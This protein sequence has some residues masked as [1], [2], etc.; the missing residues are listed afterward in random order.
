MAGRCFGSTGKLLTDGGGLYV[1]IAY[2]LRKC[3]YC[4]FFSAGVRIADWSRYVDA[5]CNELAHRSHE[6]AW[7]LRTVYFGGGTP[8]LMPEEEFIRLSTFLKPYMA[9]VEE[10]TIE[11]NPDD[12]DDHMLGVWK[13]GGINRLSIGIQTFDDDA[14]R[15]IGRRH[16]SKIAKEAYKRARN[17]FGNISIDLMFG[18]PGQSIEAWRKDIQ[19]AIDM[20]PEHISAYSLMYEEGTALT[21]L[22]DSGRLME[23]PEELSE[24]MFTILVEELSRA[25]YDHYEISNFAL[26]GYRSRHNSSYWLQKP[27]IGLGPS[28]HSYDGLRE[29]KS[30]RATL[31]DYMGHWTMEYTDAYEQ[32]DNITETETLSDEEL[33]EEYILTRMRMREGIPLQDYRNRFGDMACIGLVKSCAELA[34]RGLVLI[35]DTHI[36]LTEKAILLSDSVILEIAANC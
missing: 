7:P 17:V 19:T 12:V 21:A 20:H 33:K 18:L 22:R 6:L 13:N 26:P 11:V 1:H 25:G 34:D 29:R 32:D 5:L 4:D 36:S 8:S 9:D 16:D 2:C 3:L 14:L 28:A 31:N 10:F 23:A 27:Y 35:N 30:N 24:T 15:A